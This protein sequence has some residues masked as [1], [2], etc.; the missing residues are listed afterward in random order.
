LTFA[1]KAALG[2][3]QI[4]LALFGFFE[5]KK[6]GFGSCLNDLTVILCYHLVHPLPDKLPDGV[7]ITH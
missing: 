1:P 5:V 3:S 4:W 6:V 2:D 7:S